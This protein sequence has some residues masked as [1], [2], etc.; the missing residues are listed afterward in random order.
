MVKMILSRDAYQHK[1]IFLQ[2][3][4]PVRCFSILKLVPVMLG[5]LSM[6]YLKDKQKKLASLL[7][8]D[9]ALL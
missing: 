8:I 9:F 6:G 7:T 3:A 4:K 5:K 1:L 2:S